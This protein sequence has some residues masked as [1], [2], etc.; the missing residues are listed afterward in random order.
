[1]D[2]GVI[3]K[4]DDQVQESIQRMCPGNASRVSWKVHIQRMIKSVLESTYSKDD[5]ACPGNA[6]IN[7]KDECKNKGIREI[8]RSNEN[9]RSHNE[10]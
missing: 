1:M 4:T 9:Q 7:S 10:Q 3:E 6:G 5:Q 8:C 2:G